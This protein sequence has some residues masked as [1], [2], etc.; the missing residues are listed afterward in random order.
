[1]DSLCLAFSG[2]WKDYMLTTQ[3]QLAD[4]D[5]SSNSRHT[6][7]HPRRIVKSA[8]KKRNT[9]KVHHK[10]HNSEN[11]KRNTVKILHKTNVNVG[12]LLRA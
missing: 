6:I 7:H 5:P 9:V 2:L 12:R 4:K 8:L 11:E 10:K 1:M 3:S